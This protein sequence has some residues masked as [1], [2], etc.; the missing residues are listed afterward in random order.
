M[1][2]ISYIR[3]FVMVILFCF[4]VYNLY[5]AAFTDPGYLPRG[6]EPVPPRHQQLKP[7][8]SKFCGTC[9]IWRP[10][11]AKHCRYCNCCVRKFDHHCPWVGTCVGE[12]NYKYFTMFVYA[13]SLYA[14][15]C[16]AMSGLLLWTQCKDRTHE[17]LE[18]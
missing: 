4:V 6:N 9:K 8:G 15:Y 18:D 5:R 17:N 10:S 7:N 2:V 1:E 3:Y 11:R 13:L 16:A 12:R 14:L